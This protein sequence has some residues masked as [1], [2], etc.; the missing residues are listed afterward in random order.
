MSGSST[1]DVG[2]FGVPLVDPAALVV[3]ENPA[4]QI[5]T[6]QDAAL[7]EVATVTQASAQ[8]EA[9]KSAAMAEIEDAERALGAQGT[10]ASDSMNPTIDL[11]ATAL[12]MTDGG[13][14]AAAMMG[15]ASIAQTVGYAATDRSSKSGEGES[16]S[17]GQDEGAITADEWLNRSAARRMEEVMQAQAASAPVAGYERIEARAIRIDLSTAANADLE[18]LQ[19]ENM[20]GRSYFPSTSTS[21]KSA[22]ENPEGLSADKQMELQARIVL[23]RAHIGGIAGVSVQRGTNSEMAFSYGE[24]LRSEYGLRG[25]ANE[26]VYQPQEPIFNPM[27]LA[28]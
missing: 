20:K 22:S 4:A 12:A 23:A 1:Y 7:S 9:E 14:L 6:M 18:L 3:S 28:A 16:G 10:T 25:P 11:A 8:A 5:E 19:T 2:D 27:A 24:R 26:E 15:A 13:M 21:E 17:Q